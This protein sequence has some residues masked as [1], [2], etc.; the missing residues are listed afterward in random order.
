MSLESQ[1]EADAE[2][3]RARWQGEGVAPRPR[4]QRHGAFAPP[5]RPERVWL[6]WLLIA[7]AALVGGGARMATADWGLPYALHVDEKGFVVHEALAA[8]YRGLTRGDFR[9]RNTAYGPL[10]FELVIATKW[11]LFG[12]PDAARAVV[13]HYPND[14]AYVGRALTTETTRTTVSLPDLLYALRLVAGVLGALTILLLGFTAARLESP[15]AGAIAATLAAGSVGLF[16]VAHFYTAESLLVFAIALFLHACARLATGPARVTVVLEAGLA[17]ALIAGSK[18]PGLACLVALPAALASHRQLAGAP[19]TRWRSGMTLLRASVSAPVLLSLAVAVLAYAALNPWLVSTNPASYFRGVADNRSGAALLAL[20]FNEREFGFYDWRFTYNDSLPFW[21]H[22]AQLLPYALGGPSCCVAYAALGRGLRRRSPL[23]RI[24]F[25]GVVPP[26]LLVGAFA[27]VTVR[28]V[29]PA[30]PALILG[31][32]SLLAHPPSFGV[33]APAQNTVRATGR[34]EALAG[35]RGFAVVTVGGLVLAF[36]C[37]RGLAYALMFDEPD[38]RVLAGRYLAEHAGP[39]DVVVLEPEGS[40]T[41]VLNDDYDLVGRVL[42]GVRGTGGGRWL[43]AS[44]PA[45]AARLPTRRLFSRSPTQAALPGHLER[46]LAGARFVVVGDWYH[47]RALH[48]SAPTRAPAQHA[49]YRDLFAE[50][51]G[52]RVVARFP[53]QPRFPDFD[54]GYAWD[55]QDEEALSVCFDHMPVT[56]FERVPEQAAATPENHE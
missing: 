7:L 31:A 30:V 39:R 48:R 3:A 20:Q 32:A 43:A 44:V 28:Y 33:S 19:V 54:W 26:L 34:A 50:Q 8:E 4:V 35:L 17:I 10:V 29:L 41:A 42:P 25:W 49:F 22:L 24:V 38:P 14:W 11:A 27:V 2:E 56:I 1:V 9:P 40:Y 18:G 21:P 5:T 6:P 47:R 12:G 13:A 36:T 55:E 37:A 52:F 46:T 53:R 23:D 15:R 51:L 16:Q 45:E